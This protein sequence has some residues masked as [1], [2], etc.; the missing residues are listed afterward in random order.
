MNLSGYACLSRPLIPNQWVLL[1]VLPGSDLDLNLDP[2]L[3]MVSNL[4]FDLVLDLELELGRTARVLG[5]TKTKTETWGRN[6]GKGKGNKGKRKRESLERVQSDQHWETQCRNVDVVTGMEDRLHGRVDQPRRRRPS[7]PMEF[8]VKTN[9]GDQLQRAGRTTQECLNVVHL[10][11]M[12]SP[13][14]ILL[15]GSATPKPVPNVAARRIVAL[16]T[17]KE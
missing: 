15:Q 8:R 2:K 11:M 16:G 13:T 6:K 7:R 14:A 12:N 9:S 10:V 4:E 17:V 5:R 1:E 3:D